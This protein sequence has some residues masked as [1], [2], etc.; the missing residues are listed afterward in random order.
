LE[1]LTIQTL[2]L[3]VDKSRHL[4]QSKWH[5]HPLNANQQKYAAIDVFIGQKIYEHILSRQKKEA[6]DLEGFFNVYGEELNAA[7]GLLKKNDLNDE[8]EKL[9]QGAK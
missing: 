7:E 1:R 4:R 3:R 8:I 5:I 6:V 9:M 2:K